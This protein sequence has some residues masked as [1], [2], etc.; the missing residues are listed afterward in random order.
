MEVMV[1]IFNEVIG[2]GI[3]QSIDI[4]KAGEWGVSGFRPLWLGLVIMR[5]KWRLLSD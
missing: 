5:R 2:G 4:P 1:A 3:L